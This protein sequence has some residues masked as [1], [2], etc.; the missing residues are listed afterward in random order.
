MS[1]FTSYSA[2][3]ERNASVLRNTPADLLNRVEARIRHDEGYPVSGDMIRV[4]THTR[5]SIRRDAVRRR[6]VRLD[7]LEK[8]EGCIG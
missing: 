6:L 8:S 1:A 4:I 5:P 3:G 7:L 2:T